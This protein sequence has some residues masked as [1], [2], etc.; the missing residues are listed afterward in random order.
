MIGVERI[1]RFVSPKGLD[2]PSRL[3]AETKTRS[4]IVVDGVDRTYFHF[5]I[6]RCVSQVPHYF[7]RHFDI[8]SNKKRK[9]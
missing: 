8:F 5:C 2:A 9:S 1:S 4:K 3:L 6:Q 7:G